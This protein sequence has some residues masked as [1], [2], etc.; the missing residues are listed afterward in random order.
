MDGEKVLLLKHAHSG[1]NMYLHCLDMW[2][3]PLAADALL[4]ARSR[5]VEPSHWEITSKT[6]RGREYKPDS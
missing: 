4:S 5:C 1:S 2:C 6:T 3:V